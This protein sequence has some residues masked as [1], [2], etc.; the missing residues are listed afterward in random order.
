MVLADILAPMLDAA[1][2]SG[3]SLW[4]R[5]RS[6]AIPELEQVANRVLSI[7]AGLARG[8]FTQLTAKELLVMQ[9]DSAVDVLV[10]MTELIV[11]EAETIINAALAAIRGVVNT[12]VGFALI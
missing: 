9:I 4:D 8:V 10:A 7:E 5:A 12:A 11:F 6:F 3:A 2:A 1:S